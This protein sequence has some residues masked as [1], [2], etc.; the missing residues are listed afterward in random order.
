[1][2]LHVAAIYMKTMGSKHKLCFASLLEYC[3][4]CNFFEFTFYHP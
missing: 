2:S 4:L 1:M 3:I